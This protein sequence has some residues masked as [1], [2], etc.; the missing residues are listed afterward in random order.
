MVKVVFAFYPLFVAYNYGIALLSSICRS[1]GIDTELML[2]DYPWKFQE[3]LL[4]S[5]PDY[6][7]FSAVTAHD[8]GRMKP[9]LTSAKDMG[10]KVLLGGTYASLGVENDLCDHICRGDGET[11]P[12][13]LLNQDTRLF[14][15]RMI[16]DD[17][18]SLPLPD[19][20]MFEGIPF[21]RDVPSL[22]GKKVL[23]Y[24]SSRGCIGK[25]SFCQTRMQPAGVRIRRRVE[26]DLSQI[27]ERYKPDAIFMG[28]A[29]LPYYDRKWRE[30]WGDLRVPF[31]AYI[32]ADATEEQLKWLIDRGMLACAFGIESGN[33]SHRN[34]V[35]KKGITDEQIWKTIGILREHGIDYYPFYMVNT[36]GE[37]FLHRKETH[38]F[39]K[40]VGGYPFFYEYEELGR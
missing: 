39:A 9:F 19:Y 5:E 28:D 8:Y 21:N 1:R 25:C 10:L 36:P 11:L 18:D 27:M 15:E 38:L 24:F 17:L 12:D 34:D 23:P 22:E 3:Q 7:C 14:D 13:F 20:E 40:M 6:V 29:M 4:D 37:T 32:R 30:S 2:L 33:E 31:H 35:L 26:T 16:C